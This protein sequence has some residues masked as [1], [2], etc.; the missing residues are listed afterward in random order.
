MVPLNTPTA[1]NTTQILIQAEQV[2][3]FWDHIEA[4][5]DIAPDIAQDYLERF[6]SAARRQ[7][8]DL[9]AELI[10]GDFDDTDVTGF[11]SDDCPESIEVLGFHEVL[12]DLET[13]VE[14]SVDDESDPLN[15]PL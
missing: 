10:D 4:M 7:S 12:F 15:F 14:L 6:D 5:L 9:T 8:N 2:A 11:F 3:W 13:G 1:Q